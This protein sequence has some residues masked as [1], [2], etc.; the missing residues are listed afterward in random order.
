MNHLVG[1]VVF[2]KDESLIKKLELQVHRV[3]E[4][5]E[6]LEKKLVIAVSGGQDSLALLHV[7]AN[8]KSSL[9]PNLCVAHLDHGIRASGSAD[10]SFVR[11]EAERLGL[12]F[13]TKKVD[14]VAYKLSNK[15]TLEEAG[16]ELRYEFL[17][18]VCETEDASAILL[19]H[20]SDDQA[21]TVL[22]NLARGSGVKGVSGMA[23]V[24]NIP[25]KRF[26]SALIV[27][28]FL[29]ITRDETL[30]YCRA[31]NLSPRRDP[32]NLSLKFSRNRIRLEALPVLEKLNPM[33]KGN[34]ARFSGIL[35]QVNDYLDQEVARVWPSIVTIH[36]KNIHIKREPLDLLHSA[37]RQHL[38]R[39]AFTRVKG[40]SQDLSKLQV[41][42][43]ERALSNRPGS[44]IELGADIVLVTGYAELY[45][46]FKDDIIERQALPEDLMVEIP[47]RSE[48]NEWLV[49]ADIVNLACE[50]EESKLVECLDM[51]ALGSP[52]WVRHRVPG[53]KFLPLGLS[54]EKK[55]QDF[56]VDS[57]IPRYT[58]DKVPLLVS[59]KGIAWVVGWRLSHWAKVTKQTQ[60]VVRVEF[61]KRK[62]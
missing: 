16:R 14:T 11:R 50:Y 62:A 52:L 53:D 37:L 55:L 2:L 28:P 43:M 59:P 27:R 39:V 61:E 4:K 34:I 42:R 51:E 24:S 54:G 1:E 3:L 40:T 47:G 7:L 26:G 36:D 45:L 48:V 49:R 25:M 23:V 57:K 12:T 6:L 46:G 44:T 18:S 60:R 22:M 17:G 20:T 33:A 19:A 5:D 29:G 15:I 21:E 38:L 10:S 41:G 8:I 31:N 30:A 32:S 9:G 56:M 13:F 35:G 58:R